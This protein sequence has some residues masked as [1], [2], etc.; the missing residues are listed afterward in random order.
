[1]INDIEQLIK[2]H[3]RLIESEAYKYA[4]FIPVTF[5]LTEAYRL[6]RNAAATYD[7]KSG[8]KFSTH[9]TNQLQKLSRLSTQFGGTVRVPEN[10]QFKINKLNQI[11]AG[12][13]DQYGR[14]PTA[15]ELAD[16]SGMPMAQVHNLLTARKKDINLA[17]LAYS[18]VFYEGED[19][20]W[21]HFVYHDLTD[22][23]KLIFEY[24]TGYA[25]KPQL[26]NNQ[27]AKKLNISP[28]TVSQRVKMMSEK[29]AQGLA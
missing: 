3:K 19:D 14:V 17:N 4:K 7:A 9:L 28:S 18:P 16:A 2:D 27:I 12:L 8:I 6:A 29:I 23:D 20:D 24:R 10:K 25:G 22:K 15:A 5:V 1:M 13:Q 11:E 21:V 26:D